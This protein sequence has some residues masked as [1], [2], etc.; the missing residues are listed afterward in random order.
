MWI[1]VAFPDFFGGNWEG[2]DDFCWA[3]EGKP[4]GSPSV[5][6]LQRLKI[7]NFLLKIM[8]FDEN[9]GILDLW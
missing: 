2:T 5:G 4:G 9:D 8:I 1:G 7:L 3:G 6:R